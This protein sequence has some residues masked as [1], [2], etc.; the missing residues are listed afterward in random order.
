M[1]KLLACRGDRQV[2][3]VGKW[4]TEATKENTPKTVEFP[5]IFSLLIKQ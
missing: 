3:A 5:P 4:L 1:Q 2:E